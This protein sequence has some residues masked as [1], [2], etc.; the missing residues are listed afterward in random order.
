MNWINL[1]PKCPQHGRQHLFAQR[2]WKD[3]KEEINYKCM[4]G[5]PHWSS[6]IE[7]SYFNWLNDKYDWMSDRE[8]YFSS[9]GCQECHSTGLHHRRCSKK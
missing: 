2:T 8:D 7:R 9:G 6:D 1:P 4:V 5:K 3:G